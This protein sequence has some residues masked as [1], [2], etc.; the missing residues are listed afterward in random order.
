M[1]SRTVSRILP[2]SA[3][4]RSCVS[5]RWATSA[6]LLRTSSSPSP[7][8]AA[9]APSASHGFA[10]DEKKD[11]TPPTEVGREEAAAGGTAR[12]AA[13]AAVE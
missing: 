1:E 4:V 11:R 2:P 9:G 7:F 5:A 12:T 13:A 6:A 10:Y 8:P 3:L